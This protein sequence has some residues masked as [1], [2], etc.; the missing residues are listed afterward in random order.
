MKLLDFN[1][2]KKEN[3]QTYKQ[4]NELTNKRQGNEKKSKQTKNKTT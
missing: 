1:N 2:F 3:C 4:K